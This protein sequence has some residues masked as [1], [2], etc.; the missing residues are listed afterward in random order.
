MNILKGRQLNP[1]K[2]KEF[3]K[4]ANA[5]YK[6]LNPEKHKETLQKADVLYRQSN[7]KK[8]KTSTHKSS[9]LYRQL[10]PEKVNTSSK[11]AHIKYKQNHPENYKISQK[12]QYLKRK[13]PDS[14][15][16]L[17]QALNRRKI[18]KRNPEPQ[19]SIQEGIGM[20]HK[21]ISVGPE[22]ICMCSEQL[23]DKS[24]LTKCNPDLYKSCTRE[25][26]NLCLV[27]LKSI[28]NTEWI[29]S[30]CHSNLKAGK[31]PAFMPRQIK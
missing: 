7:L 20:F 17:G 11:I 10:H 23:W 24:S 21:D 22:Y 18:C 1:E 3:Q 25:I 28:D 27:G 30:T 16:D 19:I 4:I 8:A 6:Q 26:L 2:L 14:E 5:A 12:A 9:A 31:L 29:C 13:L 15:T